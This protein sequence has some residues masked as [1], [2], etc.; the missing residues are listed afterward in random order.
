[1]KGKIFIG[2]ISAAVT[3][4]II[5]D[6]NV[7]DTESATVWLGSFVTIT[8]AA[9]IAASSP[10]IFRSKFNSPLFQSVCLI[11]SFG[12]LAGYS[13]SE[14]EKKQQLNSKYNDLLIEQL[15]TVSGNDCKHKE[16]IYESLNQCANGDLSENEKTLLKE[17]LKRKIIQ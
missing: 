13:L 12:L 17:A 5:N 15:N 9:L 14:K 10:I 6:F 1:M 4:F 16:I 3:S 7:N 8:V 11:I 2:I